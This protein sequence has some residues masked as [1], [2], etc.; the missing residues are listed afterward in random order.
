[1]HIE[2]EEI[3]QIEAKLFFSSHQDSLLSSLGVSGCW[4]DD[5]ENN[6]DDQKQLSLQLQPHIEA[7]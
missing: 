6:K 7:P 4:N 2:M 1:M 5:H 3:V